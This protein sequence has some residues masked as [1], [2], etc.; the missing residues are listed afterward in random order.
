[1]EYDVVRC[2]KGGATSRTYLV[3]LKDNGAYRVLKEFDAEG[4]NWEYYSTEA[5]I[6]KKRLHKGIPLLYS[7]EESDGKLRILEEYVEGMSFAA[8]LLEAK[9]PE[10]LLF[11]IMEVCRIL[12]CL[13]EDGFVYM[14]LKPEHILCGRERVYLVDFGNCRRIGEQTTGKLTEYYAAPEQFDEAV[15]GVHM[16]IYSIGVLL[17][18]VWNHFESLNIQ[19][20]GQKMQLWSRLPGVIAR[21]VMPEVNQRY[22]NI[23]ALMSA[24]HKQGVVHK[25]IHI[26][27][28]RAYIGCTHLALSFGKYLQAVGRDVTYVSLGE[29]DAYQALLENA[30]LQSTYGTKRHLSWNKGLQ[31]ESQCDTQGV[32]LYEGIRVQN[33]D[34]YYLGDEPSDTIWICDYGAFEEQP[35]GR[36]SLGEEVVGI[37]VISGA[38]QWNDRKKLIKYVEYLKQQCGERMIFVGNFVDKKDC[39]A[40]EQHLGTEILYMPFY[41]VDNQEISQVRR[42]MKQL[43]NRVEQLCDE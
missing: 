10:Q 30:G 2:L 11:C 1:M 34:W 6:L 13:H 14:D 28:M 38:A 4:E 35:D 33:H 37:V 39:R 43:K 42:F 12:Q 40:L 8:L 36:C 9:K 20:K 18:E 31:S 27:G 17:M 26:Y 29:H 24:F 21:C 5:M 16:D 41:S 25:K 23:E 22:H 32:Y 7:L 3:Q 15:A 19:T